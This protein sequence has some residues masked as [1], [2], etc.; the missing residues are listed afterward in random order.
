MNEQ[1]DNA[2]YKKNPRPLTFCSEFSVVPREPSEIS[3]DFLSR[4]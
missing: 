1:E 2:D 4:C 3:G